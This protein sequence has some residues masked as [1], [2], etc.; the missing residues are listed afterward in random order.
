M[1]FQKKGSIKVSYDRHSGRILL[2]RYENVKC[3]LCISIHCT[4]KKKEGSYPFLP[5]VLNLLQLTLVL[6]VGVS[7]KA[8]QLHDLRIV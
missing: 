4:S 2:Y 5:L 3:L 8:G 7:C 1:P 6:V